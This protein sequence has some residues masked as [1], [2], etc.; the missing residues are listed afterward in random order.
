[1]TTAAGTAQRQALVI[2]KGGIA[3]RFHRRASNRALIDG[4]AIGR[5]LCR[6]H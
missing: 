4:E 1:M 6:R 3:E 5:R 2:A